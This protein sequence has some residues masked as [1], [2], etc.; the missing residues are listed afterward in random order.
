MASWFYLYL[1]TENPHTQTDHIE[2][3]VM[4]AT[5]IKKGNKAMS[6]MNMQNNIYIDE[7]T[8][9]YLD[10]AVTLDDGTEMDLTGC[11]AVF[12]S[13]YGNSRI[14]KLC[15]IDSDNHIKI[16]LEPEETTGYLSRWYQIRVFDNNGDVLQIIQ[17]IIYIRKAHK[18]YTQNPLVTGGEG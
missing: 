17:G 7:G 3:K 10:V 4:R 18:P 13:I 14:E 8:S 1:Y 12:T 11:S 5:T 15:D 2:A 9:H 6:C 16:K